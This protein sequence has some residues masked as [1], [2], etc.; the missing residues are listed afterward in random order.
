MYERRVL[1][2]AFFFLARAGYLSSAEIRQV[3]EWLDK[4]PKNDST[5]YLLA[6]LFAALDLSHSPP[7]SASAE[8]RIALAKDD[9]TVAHIRRKLVPSAEWKDAALKATVN[10]KWTLFL[11][12]V[13]F[14]DAAMEH[15]E[16]FRNEDLEMQIFNAV[17]GD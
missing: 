6:A 13:R 3:V 17:Q 5:S 4:N 14:R 8:L 12:E 2:Y 16:G 11:T 10:L 9:A 7:G 15:R 1:A